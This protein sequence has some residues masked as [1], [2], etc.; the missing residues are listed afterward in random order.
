MQKV[1]EFEKVSF[2]YNSNT[3]L[4][5]VD[6]V[7]QKNDFLA[8][9]GP[10]GGGK[11]TI[12]KLMLG[13]IAPDKGEIKVLGQ[14]PEKNTLK[15]GYVPQFSS[16]DRFFPISAKEVV[17]QGLI[18]KNSFTPFYP[19]K[20]LVEIENVMN[21]LGI[22]ERAKERFGDLSGGLKQRTLIARAI[23]GNPEILLLDEPVSSVDSSVEEDIY[24]MLVEFNKKMTIV[25]VSHDLGFV[26][27]YVNKVGCVNKTFV[28]HK[29][30]EM[31]SEIVDG[32]YN[33]K[34]VMIKHKC[35]I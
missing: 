4:K 20:S 12:L 15:V 7:V 19:K 3:V 27:Q 24:E 5:G 13:L 28:C 29:T 16:H 30:E 2:S 22:N 31:S 21:R 1:I 26:S 11:T 25:I 6:M 34:S 14:P 10:N 35:G 23:V 9:I 17:L 18:G 33:S 8:I 32:V